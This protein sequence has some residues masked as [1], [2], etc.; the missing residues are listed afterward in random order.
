MT[1]ACAVGAIEL[2]IAAM[3][4]AAIQIP[5]MV[6]PVCV[7]EVLHVTVLQ[8]RQASY[9]SVLVW[10]KDWKSETFLMPVNAVAKTVQD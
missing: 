4:C 2:V 10:T 5:I 3:N 7:T 6:D 1:R 8:I 9:S